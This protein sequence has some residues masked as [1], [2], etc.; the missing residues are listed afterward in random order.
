MD[1]MD[2]KF[3]PAGAATTVAHSLVVTGA[4]LCLCHITLTATRAPSGSD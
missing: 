4:E 1:D 2:P 3:R